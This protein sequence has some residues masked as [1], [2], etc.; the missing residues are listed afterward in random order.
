MNRYRTIAVIIVAIFVSGCA[1]T[2]VKR[3]GPMLA[4]P[5][6]GLVVSDA[7]STMKW[8]ER[9]EAA[10]RLSE[11]N[12][13]LAKQCPEAVLALDKIRTQVRK[14][15]D[16]SKGFRGL[17]YLGTLARFGQGTRTEVTTNVRKLMDTCPSLIPIEKLIGLF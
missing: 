1:E 15:S 10:G 7:N 14:R 13:V 8:I 2:V 5:I 17:I 4:K 11:V 16:S 12:V 3:I 6:F 9:E